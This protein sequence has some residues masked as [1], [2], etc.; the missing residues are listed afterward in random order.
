MMSKLPPF[1]NPA[2]SEDWSYRPNQRAL[3]EISQ[4]WHATHG[5]KASATDKQKV[6][7]LIIDGQKDFLFPKGS[8]FVGGRSGRG[9]ID[10]TA[11]TAEFVY[12]NLPIITDIRVTMDTH[13]PFQIFSP[14]FFLTT[15]GKYPQPFT[16]VVAE[17]SHKKPWMGNNVLV[18]K[19]GEVRPNPTV[20][21]WLCNGDYGW[22][23]KQVLHYCNELHK[24]GKYD[25][26][27][28][29]EHCILGDDGHALSGVLH[30]ARM[31]HAYVRGVQAEAE[32][33]GG[34]PLTENYSVLGPE[35]LTYFDGRPMA[36]KNSRFVKTLL[37]SNR[38]IIA[39][40]AGS[41]CVAA[42]TD[43]LLTEI[44]AQ[45][46]ELA[47]KVYVMTDCMSAVTVPDGKGGFYADFTPQ[48]ED[49]FKRWKDAGMNL[50][51]STDPVETWPGFNL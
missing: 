45:D 12:R 31:F 47:K 32:V 39:G 23:Q 16:F 34:H 6:A 22:L 50:V 13:F 27:L 38:G 37:S 21:G 36:Q 5:I 3:A 48:M 29:P 35:V 4:D 28:W 26:I 8:L 25:L 49:A 43:D 11:R 33:K 24:A 2:H 10:D 9:A 41:H 44:N 46:P 14:A 18:L 30:E 1:Y 42:S 51:K 20:A 19:N 17:E 15:E 40:Q 7:L